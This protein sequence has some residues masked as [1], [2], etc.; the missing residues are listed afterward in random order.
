LLIADEPTTA[1]DVTVQAQILELMQEL[2]RRLGM[3]I[4]LI[5]HDLGVVA[6]N[7]HRVVVMY[8]GRVVEAA[9]VYD[10]FEKPRHPYTA[11][12]LASLPQLGQRRRLTPIAGSV[13][14]VL[15]LPSGCA[16]HPRCAFR[17]DSC[18]EQVPELFPLGVDG[19][20]AAACFV[21]RDDP[22]L[23]LSVGPDK[24]A[25]D[26]MPEENLPRE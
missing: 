18:T 3:A 17:V 10:I 2:Q 19:Q 23:D 25:V 21:T 9:S 1:L 26:T 6:A 11:G 22:N 20:R 5:T 24:K 4:I 15:A 13:P 8:A 14:D 16:F 7:A 12:L